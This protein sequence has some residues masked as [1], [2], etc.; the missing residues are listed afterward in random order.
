MT[1][2]LFTPLHCVTVCVYQY[3]C[4][5]ISMYVVYPSVSLSSSL[6]AGFAETSPVYHLGAIF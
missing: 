5:C 6:L 3:V 4:V 2:L 1:G